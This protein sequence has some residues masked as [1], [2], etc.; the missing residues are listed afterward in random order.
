LAASSLAAMAVAREWSGQVL[1]AVPR[2]RHILVSP[3][4]FEYVREW[5]DLVGGAGTGSSAAGVGLD[6]VVLQ[7]G[8]VGGC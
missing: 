4:F 2:K 5:P 1:V 3:C 6:F 8:I 7:G